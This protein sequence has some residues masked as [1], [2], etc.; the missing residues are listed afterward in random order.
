M[1]KGVNK[2]NNKYIRKNRKRNIFKKRFTRKLNKTK[3][4]NINT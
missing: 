3:I 1:S 2:Y 4:Y